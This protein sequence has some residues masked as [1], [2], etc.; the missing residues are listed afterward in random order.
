MVRDGAGLYT[1]GVTRND[2]MHSRG[3]V[4]SRCWNNAAFVGEKSATNWFWPERRVESARQFLRRTIW[5]SPNPRSLSSRLPVHPQKNWPLGNYISIAGQ[6]AFAR[7]PD[8]FWG[9]TVRTRRA[10]TGPPSRLPGFRRGAIARYRGLMKLSSLIVGGDTGALHLGRRSWQTSANG[11]SNGPVPAPPFRIRTRLD[12]RA[13]GGGDVETT[14][15]GTGVG[16]RHRA[17]SE[18]SVR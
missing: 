16:C 8:P 2:R 17:L 11:L 14:R 4:I 15:T 3:T 7:S 5:I 13:T 1:R 12:R 10:G 18:S 9:W 6:L